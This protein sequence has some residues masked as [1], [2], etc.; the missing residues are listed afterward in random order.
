MTEA[1]VRRP[2]LLER[3]GVQYFER[4]AGTLPVARPTDAVHY[5]NSEER[6]GL[7]RVQVGAVARSA[8]AGALSASVSA[9][10]ELWANAFIPENVP[11]WSLA[12]LHF[13]LIVGGATAAASVIEILFI[14]WDTLRAVHRLAHVAGLDVFGPHGQGEHRA[15]AAALARAALELPNP[16]DGDVRVNPLRESSRAMLLAASLAYKAKIGV[17]N[18]LF[19]MVVRRMLGRV[20]VRSALNTLVPFVAVP[21]TALWNGV[22]TRK[23]LEEAKLRAMGPSAAEEL[24]SLVFA[25]V[26]ALSDAGRLAALR[27]VAAAIVR[28]QDLHPNLVALLEQVRQRAGDTGNAELDDVGE[29]LGSLG[30][31]PANERRVALQLLA[32]AIAV[33]GKVT[34]K[35]TRLYADALEAVGM[36][37]DLAPVVRLTRAFAHGE[38]VAVEALRAMGAPAAASAPA[39]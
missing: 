5:L 22:V 9:A 11:V 19:K 38:G 20:L 28:T 10:A 37:P 31:L 36:P 17:T 4:R 26:P 34:A 2:P 6:A 27:A 1:A 39:S 18:F 24:T 14:Y 12:S 25:E 33:D 8:L 21:V 30:A 3:V 16:V 35:E 13:W 29:F 7:R 23:V 15:I 32:V